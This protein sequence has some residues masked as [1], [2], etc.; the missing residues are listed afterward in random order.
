MS[1]FDGDWWFSILLSQIHR[2]FNFTLT[3]SLLSDIFYGLDSYLASFSS[4]FEFQLVGMGTWEMDC[5]PNWKFEIVNGIK[6]FVCQKFRFEKA[7]NDRMKYWPD[8]HPYG[9]VPCKIITFPLHIDY[10]VRGGVECHLFGVL[11]RYLSSPDIVGGR[12]AADLA[13]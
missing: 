3:S 13:I 1:L 7:P 9:E 12:L 11:D 6:R 2:K 4:S 8:D 5:F 10:H